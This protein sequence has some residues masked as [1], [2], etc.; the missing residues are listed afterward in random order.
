MQE[1]NQSKEPQAP[2]VTSLQVEGLELKGSFWEFIIIAIVGRGGKPWFGETVFFYINGIEC[3][4]SQSTE[5]GRAILPVD[6]IIAK[7]AKRFTVSAQTAVQLAPAREVI[8]LPAED[9]KKEEDAAVR[10][11][12]VATRED[13]ENLFATMARLDKKGKGNPGRI[14]YVDCHP[15]TVDTDELGIAEFTIPVQ[16]KK[17]RVLFFPTEFP[18]KRIRVYVPEKDRTAPPEQKTEVGFADKFLAAFNEG[19]ASLDSSKNRSTRE[20]ATI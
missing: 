16:D 20:E 13:T 8:V 10:I 12:I 9:K 6:G 18:Q 15:K 14:T 5:N 3:G 19:Y 4:R 11:A 2:K 7:D 1:K 17:R